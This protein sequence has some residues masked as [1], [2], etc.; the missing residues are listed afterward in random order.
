MKTTKI[1]LTISE[2][3]QNELQNIR[4]C[5]GPKNQQLLKA[6]IDEGRRARSEDTDD[7]LLSLIERFASRGFCHVYEQRS[8]KEFVIDV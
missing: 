5:D 7:Y 1:E 3:N 4:F 2:A 6:I 8:W